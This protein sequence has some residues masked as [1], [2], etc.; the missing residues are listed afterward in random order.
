MKPPRSRINDPL[1]LNRSLRAL[2][3]GL[4]RSLIPFDIGLSRSFRVVDA[5]LSRSLRTLGVGLPIS[6]LL[7]TAISLSEL[8][9]RYTPVITA[10]Q[11]STPRIQIAL[12]E[13]L[14]ESIRP[15]LFPSF[16]IVHPMA[17]H[18]QELGWV[19]HCTLPTS[20]LDETKEEDLDAAI[21]NYYRDEW[22]SVREEIEQETNHY[23]IDDDSKDIVR[24]ALIAHEMGLY[25]LVPRALLVEIERVIRIHLYENRVG[26]IDVKGKVDDFEDLPMS[27]MREIS[28]E[29]IQL[30]TFVNHLYR[31]VNT[32]KDR[33]E[34][35]YS[36]IPNRHAAVHG[37]V[38]YSSEKNSLNSIFI[39]DFAFHMVTEL[40]K[41]HIG[42]II[43][44]LR[45]RVA[46]ATD[47]ES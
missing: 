18:A 14:Y 35:E 21:T 41:E 29:I 6:H 4:G 42:G 15:T 7:Q 1:G 26:N 43:E 32:E 40:K 34:L 17:R 11:M 30:E 44:I 13:G 46:A 3:V 19:V 33:S 45:G 10:M 24:Q 39:A 20:L 38:S 27:S 23:L 9:K 25:R 8:A 2:N 31:H 12:P 16:P 36:S 28:S 22:A 47:V 37:L 5:G